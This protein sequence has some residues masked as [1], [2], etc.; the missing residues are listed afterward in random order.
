LI[1]DGLIAESA[2][3]RGGRPLDTRSDPHT[4][5]PRCDSSPSDESPIEPRPARAKVTPPRQALPPHLIIPDGESTPTAAAVQALAQRGTGPDTCKACA[6]AARKGRSPERN[7]RPPRED[8]LETLRDRRFGFSCVSTPQ[9]SG[10]NPSAGTSRRRYAAAFVEP[11]TPRGA[12]N[13]R[14]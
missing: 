6:R 2:R 8:S 1:E 4:N 10:E 14:R 3:G 9:S 12:K 13:R 7:S 5:P 11:A